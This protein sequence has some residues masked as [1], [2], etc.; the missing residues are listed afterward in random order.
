MGGGGDFNLFK[1][2]I[3]L[4]YLTNTLWRYLAM[5]LSNTQSLNVKESMVF[6]T[7]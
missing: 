2:I 3:S 6:Y 5:F 1:A 7:K 4:G